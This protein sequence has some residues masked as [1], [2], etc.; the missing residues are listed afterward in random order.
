MDELQEQ[1]SNQLA[2]LCDEVI[3]IIDQ[4]LGLKPDPESRIFY[5]KMKG[6]FNRYYLDTKDPEVKKNIEE[7]KQCYLEA[8]SLSKKLPLLNVTKLG[9][10]LNLSVFYFENLLQPGKSIQLLKDTLEESHNLIDQIPEKDF[11]E[12]TTLQQYMRDNLT[13]WTNHVNDFRQA[14]IEDGNKM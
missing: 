11:R 9:L 14:L 3:S 6:D 12:V 2:K 7:T 1:I 8:M 10:I 13:L 5:L 4:K